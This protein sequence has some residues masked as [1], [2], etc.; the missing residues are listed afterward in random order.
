MISSH[1]HRHTVLTVALLL[2]TSITPNAA[3]TGATGEGW[4]P[5]PAQNRV[6]AGRAGEEVQAKILPLPDGGFYVSWF[7]NTDGGYD[8]RLQRLDVDGRALWAENGILV[9][10]RSFDWT[11]DYGFTVDGHDHAVLS[12]QCCVQGAPDEHLVVA[13]VS[14]EG[15]L[16]WT[17]PGVAVTAPGN[18]AAVSQITA[19]DDGNSVVVWMNGSGQGMAQKFDPDG[20][21]LWNSD[22]VVI[23]GPGSAS[24]FIAD[25]KP[26]TDGEAIVSW[27]NQPTF[28]T[29]VLHAQKLA[30]LDGASLWG[31]GVRVSEAGN[32]QAGNFPPHHAD[33]AGGAVFA[34]YDSTGVAFD[35]RVQHIDSAGVRRFGNEGTIATTDTTRNHVSPAGAFDPA[36]GDTYVAW[37]DEQTINMQSWHSL[38][39]Q[40]IDANGDRQWGDDG[41][42]LVPPAIATTGENALSSPVV[43][44]APDGV[45]IAWSTGNTSVAANPIRAQYLDR[46]GEAIW[47]E[48]VAIKTSPTRTSRPA[49]ATSAAGYAAFVWSDGTDISPASNDVLGQN[50]NYD[51]SLGAES[52][53]DV[54]FADG[55]ENT[56]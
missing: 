51:G 37:V 53:D 50:L 26:G 22:G 11:T 18:T 56:D 42:E 28:L 41:L 35:I 17:S 19:T 44:T 21:P 24:R 9:A 7:D 4:S 33:G 3:A 29:R 48:P 13:R 23:T 39:V 16:A 55:F 31:T 54:I 10:D 38:R 45:I 8:V 14:P 46:D 6:I 20:T 43:L 25:V 5:D 34:Y 1:S 15:E 30:S 40:R 27:S 52:G 12:F 49:G 2:G 36:G 47:P 32:L